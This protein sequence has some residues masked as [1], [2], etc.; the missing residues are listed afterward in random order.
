[1][2]ESELTSDTGV[3]TREVQVDVDGGGQE[4]RVQLGQYS[5]FIK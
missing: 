5:G 4:V 2:N 3:L 1:M